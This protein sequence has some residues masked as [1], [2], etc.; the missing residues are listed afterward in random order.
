MK[1]TR[2]IK[3]EESPLSPYLYK[4][5]PAC[6]EDLLTALPWDKA[7]AARVEDSAVAMVEAVRKQ[8]L[9]AG[10]LESFLQH[11]S[12]NTEEGLF[13]MC[14]AEA[15]L[16]IPDK[17]TAN[18]LIADKIAAVNWL[19]AAGESK[20]WMVK[21]AGLGLSVTSKTL[22]SALSKIG[23]PFIREAMIKAMRMMGQQF[24]LGTD[25]ADAVKNAEGYKKKGYRISYDHLGEGARTDEDAERYFENYSAAI[26]YIAANI[27]KNESGPPGI[28]VK[29]S[30]L[31]PR[32]EFAQEQHCVPIITERL[33][34][35]AKKAAAHDMT[36]IVD[37]E[38]A[39]R[40]EISLDVLRGVLKDKSL[41]GWNRFGLAIQA[42]QKRCHPLIDELADMAKTAHRRLRV[43]LVKGAYWDTEIKRA[44]V[45]GLNDYPVF[46]RK[47]NTD[48]S[49]L[50]CTA[51]LFEHPECFYPYLA[52]HNAHSVAAVLEMAKDYKADY[53]FQRLHGMG[54][55][56]FNTLLQEGKV[57]ASIY[58]PVGPHEDL[59]P[60]LVRRLLENGANTSFVNKLL[61][62]KQPARDIVPDPVENARAHAERRHPKIVMPSELFKNEKPH[63]RIN[64]RGLDLTDGKT[65]QDLLQEIS[66]FDQ[67]YEAMPLIAGKVYQ[68]TI[69]EDALNPGD[70]S[71]NMGRWWPANTALVN[72]AFEKARAG[73]AHWSKT[74]AQTRAEALERY[75]DLLEENTSEIMALCIREAGKT[76]PDALAEI[77]EAVDFCRYYANR[78]RAD[79]TPQDLPGPT[80]ESNAI[81]LE[82]R[83]VFVCISPWNFP[84]AIFTGQVTAALMA[85]NA[86]IAKPAEQTP[87]IAMKAVQLMHEAGIP[88][89]VLH[90]LPGDGKIGAAVVGHKDV[91]GVAFTGSTEVAREINRT[92]AAKDGP[93]VPLIAETGGMNAMIVDSSALPEQVIDD[94][95]LSAFGS[96]GQR[97]SALRILCLQDDVADKIIHMLRGA[98]Q[99]LQVGNPALLSSDLGPVIDEE[100]RAVLVQH[101]EALKG[102]AKLVDEVPLDSELKAQG[103]YLGPCAFELP[104]LEGLEREVFGPILHIVRYKSSELDE[105]IADINAKGYGL[106]L[107]V[108]SRIDPFRKHVTA[109]VHSGNA[110]VNRSMIGAVVGSQPFGGQGLSGTGPKA[111]GPH[112]LAA[113]ANERVI[114]IDTTASGGNT[115]LVSLEE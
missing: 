51:K 72:K 44:Q 113:F 27:S 93:I 28:S 60:Y 41:E 104:G 112:Y 78:G 26:D 56:L 11:Y 97:C 48:L 65:V 71:D 85:G 74:P 87:L 67:P 2:T 18:A 103:H 63:G 77:R 110:Y 4:D 30:A 21:A 23:K 29:L 107:G 45:L 83:G 31:H 108:H 101:R 90:M 15:L 13:L 62:D 7:R 47:A 49:Y 99:E 36:F 105:L 61:S 95:I 25:I 43:R 1:N 80:G 98:M 75:A 68:D 58:A 76:L 64:S 109:N 3:K 42:Y 66:G 73:F 55:A 89:D 53:E 50:A 6:V 111:G 114:S 57:V 19:G 88:E 69:A 81:H 39:E 38:E 96:A 33:L 79:F 84:L 100:A 40:L 34:A 86:V 5:E 102:F 17:D 8:K 91:A 46:T 20:D 12:L 82:G 35:L 32:Y 37:A 14:L 52:T 16:R 22:D 10:Q 92:L 115:S 59:L 24:V 70:H 54:E 106:T 94:V 9:P